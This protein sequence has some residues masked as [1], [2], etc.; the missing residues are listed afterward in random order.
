MRYT[1]FQEKFI[2]LSEKEK[3]RLLGNIFGIDDVWVYS[4]YQRDEEIVFRIYANDIYYQ[5]DYYYVKKLERSYLVINQSQRFVLYQFYLGVDLEE[6]D[7][8]F[9]FVMTRADFN[10]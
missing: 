8:Q 6:L 7:E 2:S 4:I 9:Y 1:E 3:K 5:F 10:C